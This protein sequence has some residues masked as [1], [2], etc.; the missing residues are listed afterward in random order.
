MLTAIN[1]Q[2][3]TAGQL[4]YNEALYKNLESLVIEIQSLIK[5]FREHP[6]K[7]VKLEMF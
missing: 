4:I 6:K 3:G 2:E 7:Y 1:T 5:D